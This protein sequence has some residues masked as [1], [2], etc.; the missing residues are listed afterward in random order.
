MDKS[1]VY[2]ETSVI[3][4]LTAL[5][6]RD[7]VVAAHQ[8]VTAEWWQGRERFQL[9]V[10]D[11]VLEEIARGDVAAAARRR[12]AVQGIDILSA[13][14]AAEALA[15]EF[16]RAAAMPVKAAIDAVH[17]AIAA[18]HGADFLVTWNCAHIANASVREKIE[19]VCR[20]AGFRPP[21][22]CTPLDLQG[23]EEH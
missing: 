3:S 14:P 21:V 11:A 12:A 2:V 10:S 20:A 4:Y 7:L 9:L 22:I 18:T 6:S 8:Q 16:I 19:A 17:V 23:E 13:G 1:R 15:Q 5:P